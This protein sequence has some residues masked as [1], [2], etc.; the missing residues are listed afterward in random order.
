MKGNSGFQIGT[1]VT[2]I[3]MIFVV[4]CLTTFSIL[5]YTSADADLELNKKNSSNIQ[6][7]YDAY[8][9]LNMELAK[10]DTTINRWLKEE[11]E[12]GQ[13]NGLQKIII[14]LG[15]RETGDVE[16]TYEL[17]GNA[18]NV[19]LVTDMNDK[20]QLVL[21]ATINTD[22]LSSSCV[23]NKCYVYTESDGFTQEETLPDMW[24]G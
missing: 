17:N 12:S 7:Y 21:E 1:G 14:S 3:F 11:L 2:S 19:K 10:V 15:M 22:D 20:Q 18:I 8:S 6:N 4:L 24:G 13:Q 5:S 9:K 23:V 16:A